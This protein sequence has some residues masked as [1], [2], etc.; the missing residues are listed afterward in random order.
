MLKTGYS[1]EGQRRV[2]TGYSHGGQRR[3]KTG[4]TAL[5]NSGVLK[6]GYSPGVLK[7]GYSPEAQQCVEDWVQP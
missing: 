4:Y 3:V 7:T 6:T 5:R 1:L 2:K